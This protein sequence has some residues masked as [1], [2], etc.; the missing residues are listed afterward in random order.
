MIAGGDREVYFIAFTSVRFSFISTLIA[1]GIGIPAGIALHFGLFK[2]KH[3]IVAVLNA[4][5]ALPTVVVGLF[6]FSLISR[7]GPLG[8][9]GL[10]FSPTAIIIGQVVLSLPI[11]TSLV[12]SGLSKLDNR[13][14][15]TLYTLGAGRMNIL[16]ATLVEA[17]FAILSAVLAGFGRVVGEIGVSMMLGGNIRWYTRTITTTIALETSKGLFST[18]LAL[19][20][21]LIVI[22]LVI[23]FA[24]HILA[25]EHG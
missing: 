20:I 12:F 22:A 13:F 21:I 18:A 8:S 25:R 3:A 14:S 6:V 15:E 1:S 2:A 24:L 4:L 7:S 5:M 19:G 10:L 17:R 16:S 11:I 9:L 23:N